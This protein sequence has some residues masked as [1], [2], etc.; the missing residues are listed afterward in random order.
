[1]IRNSTAAPKLS[2]S[3]SAQLQVQEKE[4]TKEI[5]TEEFNKAVSQGNKLFRNIDFRQVNFHKM[6]G[7]ENITLEN[8]N[9]QGADLSRVW[10]RNAVLIN[11]DLS[12][13]DLRESH[14]FQVTGTGST[15]I[16][17]KLDGAEMLKC[18]F[19]AGIFG[20]ASLCGT[21]I[22]NCEF[23]GCNFQRANM[24][25]A[26]ISESSKLTDCNCVAA[27]AAAPLY[28]DDTE[29]ENVTWQGADLNLVCRKCKFRKIDF[30]NTRLHHSPFLQCEF[31][32]P[33]DFDH[34]LGFDI[35]V[36]P[37]FDDVNFL[38]LWDF[39]EGIKGDR[40]FEKESRWYDND[41]WVW[42]KLFY[43]CS[44]SSARPF[45]HSVNAKVY[46]ENIKEVDPLTRRYIREKLLVLMQHIPTWDGSVLED[47]EEALAIDDALT[48][49]E[50]AEK[51]L[52]L[53]NSEDSTDSSSPSES[54]SPEKVGSLVSAKDKEHNS[55]SLFA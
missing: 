4:I 42:Q 2:I 20:D 47:C 43:C 50:N 25:G 14:F 13:A 12:D 51:M 32:G 24:S 27:H 40:R 55:F 30:S 48:A 10:I 19:D 3:S 16:E 39:P 21:R 41:R 17:A 53:R 31:Y 46:L 26:T 34:C 28:M 36:D 15:M 35:L 44:Y 6:L 37:M 18:K 9:L 11:V 49:D 5:S 23:I 52:A 8:C 7:L 45:P 1:V 29:L 33:I 54:G 22:N 38:P